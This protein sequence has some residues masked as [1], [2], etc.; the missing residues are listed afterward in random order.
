MMIGFLNQFNFYAPGS[1][2]QGGGGHIV[3]LILSVCLSICLSV[4]NFNIFHN[5]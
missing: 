5:F 1:N 4:D 3:V 2:D